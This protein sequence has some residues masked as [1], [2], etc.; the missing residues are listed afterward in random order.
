MDTATLQ[1]IAKGL[2]IPR[3]S[4]LKKLDLIYQ[5]LDVQAAKPSDNQKEALAKAESQS[6]GQ[7]N[8][9]NNQGYGG[10]GNNQ[11]GDF[12]ATPYADVGEYLK[13]DITYFEVERGY[14]SLGEATSNFTPASSLTT[15]T[16]K[17]I[18]LGK[19]V[20]AV[21]DYVSADSNLTLNSRGDGWTY[22]DYRDTYDQNT[23][24]AV[25]D[26]NGSYYI[27]KMEMQAWI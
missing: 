20:F 1:E 11:G 4:S 27:E 21:T 5:I 16:N 17:Q 3:F 15:N 8:Q 19:E 12:V 26:G 13:E 14:R 18:K 2:K 22:K 10:Q 25:A 23:V 9:G 6:S 7:Q 24:G